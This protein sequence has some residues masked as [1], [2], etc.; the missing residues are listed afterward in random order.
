M[1]ES[2]VPASVPVLKH[3]A[4]YV[5]AVAI[6]GAGVGYAVHEHRTAQNLAAQAQNMAAQNE[7]VTAALNAAR[8]QLDDLTAK[9][10]MLATRSET[11]PPPSPPTQSAT[12]R[13]AVPAQAHAQDARFN[14][15]QSEIDAQGKAIEETRSNLASTRGDLASTRTE[16]TSSIARNH[17]EL[18]LLQKK[19]ER[20]YYEFDIQKS[21]QFQHEGPVG[22]RL[23]KAN[24]K[25]QYADLQL[26]VEDQNL[27][28][29]HV[30]L[31]QPVVFY[32]PDSPQP[33]EVVI[34]NI[35]RD[36][37]HGYVSAPKYRRSELASVSSAGANPASSSSQAAPN[38]DAQPANRE[39]LPAPQ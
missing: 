11:Q 38:G 17:D 27:S 34:N 16:L 2:T 15:L 37:I 23:N 4:V 21:K 12:G 6:G 20:N 24:T 31:Y 33:V 10:N 36:H 25:H 13:R 26:M 29:K 7:Q 14:K 8:S 19:G 32:K 3:V 28:Q 9:V 39:Q 1:E 5:V 22:I 35:G 30:N 18:V